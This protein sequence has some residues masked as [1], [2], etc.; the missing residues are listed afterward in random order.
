[1]KLIIQIPCYDEEA[2]LPATLRDLPRTLP[3]VESIEF[4]VVDDGSTDR[5]VQ[6]AREFGV[7][8]IICHKA[9]R[10]LAAAFV[11]GLDASLAAG[12]DLIVNTDGDNQYHGADVERLIQPIVD[13]R[14][15]IAV[16]DRGVAALEHFSPVKRTLQRLGSWVVRWAA[17]IPI[18]DATSG[19]RTFVP[20]AALP[21]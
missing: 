15:D 20:D 1:L 9:N 18:P 17:G 5:T 2:T 8:Y 13:G 21:P 4:L 3:G 12:A 14:A 19:F 11:T 10:G 6:V 16:G 7:Q